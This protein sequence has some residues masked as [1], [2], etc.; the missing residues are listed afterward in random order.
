M[1][2]NP[3]AFLSAGAV[4]L[5]FPGLAHAF[6]LLSTSSGQVGSVDVSTGIFTPEL[7]GPVFT[8]I[9]LSESGQLFGSTFNALYRLDRTLGTSSLVG[10]FPASINGLG[11]SIDNILYG[12]GS[13]GFYQINTTTGLASLVANI[14]GFSSSGD[15]VFNPA[16]GQFLATST[17]SGDSLW[18]I[19]LDGNATKIGNIGF[20]AVY[21]LFFE[22][23]RLYGYTS[24]QQIL[25]DLATGSG[26]LDKQL[27]GLQGSVWG[28]ASL[29]S[30]GPQSP[31]TPVKPVPEPTHLVGL[32]AIGM[33]LFKKSILQKLSQPLPIR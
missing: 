33:W 32:L 10:S 13:S 22:N 12:T 24:Q 18:S 9:A 14:P 25:I 31:G 21:G 27:T 19:A 23:G 5:S 2:I 28:T 29:P 30:S 17:G 8:D 11:F 16:T 6:T 4:V 7:N 1:K 15:L 3:L 26:I 20:S